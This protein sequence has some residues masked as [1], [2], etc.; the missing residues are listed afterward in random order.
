[1][2]EES[3][4][5]EKLKAKC[6]KCLKYDAVEFKGEI[7]DR[8]VFKCKFCDFGKS[9]RVESGQMAPGVNKR[10]LEANGFG[11]VDKLL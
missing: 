3:K 1:M 2:S 8:Y 7:G 5:Y 4:W 9:R 11:A 6:P 10:F